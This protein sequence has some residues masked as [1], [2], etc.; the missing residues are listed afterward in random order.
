MTTA[1]YGAPPKALADTGPDAV[2]LSPLMPGGASLETVADGELSEL[3]MLTPPGTFER[4]YVLALGL[5]TLVPGGTLTAMAPKDRGGSRL[6][7][8]LQSFGCAVTEMVKAHHRICVAPRP[9]AIA[10]LDDAIAA[11]APRMTEP[12]GLWSQPG[13]FSWDRIDPG[14]A[15][16]AQNLPTLSGE[17]ADLGCG[18]GYLARSVLTSPKV[19]RIAL[20]DLDR[21]AVDCARR[22]V[23]DPRASFSWADA[24]IA[25]APLSGLDFVVMNPPFHDGGTEDRSLG[26][27]FIRRAASALR[28]GGALWMVANRHLPYEAVLGDLFTSVEIK[29]DQ[30]GYKVFEA[31][32]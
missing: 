27:A 14:T 18:I 9:E 17:G 22:N 31:H 6:R 4:R 28:K 26:Q 5:R 16:L 24:T 32:K 20:I 29:A 10:G 15:L 23:D 1:V 19:K 3:T 21:R 7:K 2:Q 25:D 13:V 8:E 11:G 12:H 30:S